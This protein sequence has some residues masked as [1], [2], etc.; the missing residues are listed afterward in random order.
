[1]KEILIIPIKQ[2][3]LLIFLFK[4]ILYLNI[5]KYSI[6]SRCENREQPFYKYNSYCASSCT[7]EEV[8][9]NVCKIE[10]D[11]IKIQWLNNIIHIGGRG[12]AYV[13]LAVSEKNNLYF[14]TTSYPPS[15]ERSFYLLD[16][17]GYGIINKDNPQTTIEINDPGKLGRYESEGYVIKL[18]ESDDDKEY[19]I[20]MSK[21]GQYIES[22]D[23]I[24]NENYFGKLEYV[25]SLH[26][27]YSIIGVHL[28]LKLANNENKN[29]YL[30]GILAYYYDIEG[31]GEPNLF[32]SKTNFTS[33]NINNTLPIYEFKKIKVSESKIV[34]CFETNSNYIMCF[35]ENDQHLYT[36]IVFDYELTEKKQLPI[37]NGI[38][39]SN[40][41]EYFFYCI[42]FFNDS[43]VFAYFDSNN[44]ITFEFR[45]YFSNN[46]TIANHFSQYINIKL[47]A[48]LSH[49]KITLCDMIKVK[50]KH[51]YFAGA[52]TNRDALIIISIFN[53]NEENLSI[54]LY[55]VNMK[56]MYEYE[57]SE[58]IKLALYKNFLAM[59]SSFYE[60]TDEYKAYSSLIIFSYTIATEQSLDLINYIYHHNETKIYNLLIEFD[61]NG[62]YAID[63]NLFGLVYSGIEI[64]G[65][66][67]DSENIYLADLNNERIVSN[68]FLPKNESIKLIIPKSNTYEPFSCRFKYSV[69]VTEPEFSKFNNY[70]SFYFDSGNAAQDQL[71]EVFYDKI[72][73][74]YAGKSNIFTLF[75]N[76]TLTEVNCETNCELCYSE[77]NSECISCKYL[78]YYE[79]SKIVCEDNPFEVEET[80]TLTE[81]SVTTEKTY[82][83]AP[84]EETDTPTEETD[85]PTEETDEPT[86]ETDKQTEET[87]TPTEETD[88][89]TEETDTPTE[90][91]DKQ[92]EETDK[93]EKISE[94]NIKNENNEKQTHGEVCKFEEIIN[95]KCGGEISNNQIIDVYSHIKE[96]LINSNHTI[97]KTENVIFEVSAI[98]DQLKS[99]NKD[100]SNV[101]L[102]LCEL[103][104]KSK[105]NISDSQNLI[106]FKIDI[107]NLE[108]STTYVKYEIYHPETLK[109][110][111]LDICSD[112]K[113]NIFAPVY[114]NDEELSLFSSLDKAGYN[115]FDSNDSFYNDFCTPYTT[116]NG[117]DIL[118]ED[119]KKDIYSKNGNKTLC[120]DEC[121][122][123][124]FNETS[125]K[126]NCNCTPQVSEMN[127]NTEEGILSTLQFGK[128]Q[129][130][131]SFFNTLSN[132]NF[133][134][135]KCF[136][137]AFD[138]KNFFQN[139]GRII[140]TVIAF[141]IF[142]CII[143]YFINGNRQLENYLAQILNQKMYYNDKNNREIIN[144]KPKKKP[145]KK[146]K[147]S[148]KK[149]ENKNTK[150]R[151]KSFHNKKSNQSKIL[152]NQNNNN[153]NNNSDKISLNNNNHNKSN[154]IYAHKSEKANIFNIN[155]KV[156]N[157]DPNVIRIKKKTSKTCKLKS[158]NID[159][160]NKV[161][162][163]S[164]IINSSVVPKKKEIAIDESKNNS[165]SSADKNRT[166]QNIIIS[167]NVYIKMNKGRGTKKHKRTTRLKN[168]KDSFISGDIK[169]KGHILNQS[170][171]MDKLD[172][173]YNKIIPT[174]FTAQELNTM[175]YKQALIYDK[176]TFFQYYISLIKKKQLILF[177]I[178]SDRDYNLITI[179]VVLFFISFSLY[180]T[181][182]G[183]FFND[184]T[185]HKIYA[186]NGTYDI[187]AQLPII[188]YSTL[189]TAVINMI[190]R[191]L[192]LSEKNM[193]EIKQEK[194]FNQAKKRAK[195]IWNCIKLKIYIFFILS[196]L[197]ML[198][199]WYFISCFCSVYKN[200]QIILISDTLISFGLSML[201]PFGIFLIPGM[202]RIPALRSKS[203][204]KECLYKISVFISMA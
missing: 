16:N 12:C 51:F 134:V 139:I 185:M 70:T 202:F 189:I 97:I 76:K 37:A 71:E 119:R 113:I 15:N 110:L 123:L 52:S 94:T 19:F 176:R 66:C 184:N 127:L 30:I 104:L 31:N 33:I 93:N 126:A 107:K 78:S 179:K 23:F 155:K 82:T 201:Y 168:S 27:I 57:F 73:N 59:G 112:L 132:S 92:T 72:K 62:T 80:T 91:T 136:K 42:H 55:K 160:Q 195:D 137:L 198:F 25:F 117:T 194:N 46:N 11:I 138:F 53:Y 29:T 63:N 183:F 67:L 95:N 22:Y 14:L 116:V 49:K 149:I 153:N 175:G 9:N 192:S 161:P 38:T 88:A 114:L 130:E 151:S 10:N 131:E 169:P 199:F 96:N 61:V 145:L 43:G 158:G 204:D 32:L 106:I 147:N 90:E 40:E 8:K 196:I 65:N 75:I 150:K 200:T 60:P 170:D 115:L 165:I 146:G 142:V 122:L 34:S 47:N 118:L 44:E 17:E 39:N 85:A 121:E 187:L 45:R 190:L 166:N 167:K 68:Y 186:N 163:N 188:F 35:F 159:M 83:D 84:T 41:N 81:S 156:N 64:V 24:G 74:N 7:R 203:K 174:N 48:A 157:Q 120:Q 143:I 177:T 26:N 28:K 50:D 180:F 141:F 3:N 125:Q 128:N 191:T 135:L 4:F 162:D 1:M 13:S 20:S 144:N 56:Y 105:Y 69:V 99:D 171:S 89:P 77:R 87:D 152:L 193:L 140:M 58:Y 124:F 2:K 36:I 197:L 100:I 182:N 108:E 86:E 6:L 54:R 79:E 164:K 133:Q 148:V 101:D 181:L 178:I 5:I 109:K 98:E 102:G 18:Y 103:R 173:S 154:I 172:N 111:E 21:A 129:L